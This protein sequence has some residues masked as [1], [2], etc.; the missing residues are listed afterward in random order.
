MMSDF[1]S[2]TAYLS[3][4]HDR[5]DA[6]LA[7]AFEPVLRGNLAAALPV[8]EELAEGLLRHIRIEEEILFPVFEQRSGMLSGPTQVM[9]MEHRVLQRV[10]NR[11]RDALVAGDA[12]AARLGHDDLVEILVAHHVKEEEVLYPLTDRSLPEQERVELTRK[13]VES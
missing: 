6:L 10:L 1:P 9:R 13:L 12:E 4:D 7:Q 5:L 11:M 3:W 2:V 8:F